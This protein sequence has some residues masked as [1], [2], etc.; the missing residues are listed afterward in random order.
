MEAST[1]NAINEFYFRN[2]TMAAITETLSGQMGSSSEMVAVVVV[3][4]DRF[5][6]SGRLTG[7]RRKR[8]LGDR[9]GSDV[10]FADFDEDTR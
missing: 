5:L 2:A 3:A 8:G 6:G 1:G 10:D 4:I 7:C 9:V